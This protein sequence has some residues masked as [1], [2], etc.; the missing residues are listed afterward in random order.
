MANTNSVA[1]STSFLFDAVDGLLQFSR[2]VGAVPIFSAVASN[3][4]CGCFVPSTHFCSSRYSM[5]FARSAVKRAVKCYP[6]TD[7]VMPSAAL[8]FFPQQRLPPQSYPLLELINSQE[9]Q[10]LLVQK[11]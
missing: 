8:M 4:P 2:R 3:N 10:A 7:T 6:I 1:L 5:S 11:Q 9:E